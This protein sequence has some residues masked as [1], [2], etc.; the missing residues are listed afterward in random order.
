MKGKSFEY[1]NKLGN[2]K[3]H[4][5]TLQFSHMNSVWILFMWEGCKVHTC[6]LE[7]SKQIPFSS[8]HHVGN[9]HNKK[10]GY[11]D[12]KFSNCHIQWLRWNLE[13]FGVGN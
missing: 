11:A 8:S 4:A 9:N 2:A 13:Q 6:N 3:L 5:C 1:E 12:V 10:A 7:G